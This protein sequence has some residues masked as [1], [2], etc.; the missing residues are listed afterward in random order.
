MDSFIC[1]PQ[2]CELSEREGLDYTTLPG[3]FDVH[4]VSNVKGGIFDEATHTFSF[5]GDVD[6][7][8]YDYDLENGYAETFKP[9]T[10]IPFVPSVPET[11]PAESIVPE[12]NPTET[13]VPETKPSAPNITLNTGDLSSVG[14]YVS[15]FIASAG[16]VT[17]LLGKKNKRK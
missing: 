3:Q 12:T 13:T 9:T 15:S 17:V 6:E 7:A 5:V 2:T 11:N 14:L 8:T 10:K 4:K 16:A 1:Y